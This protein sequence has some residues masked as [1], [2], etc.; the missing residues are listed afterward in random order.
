MKTIE[1]LRITISLALIYFAIGSLLNLLSLKLIIIIFGL[2][3]IS[4]KLYQLMKE[5]KL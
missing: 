4:I 3:A 1:I 2:S 5:D